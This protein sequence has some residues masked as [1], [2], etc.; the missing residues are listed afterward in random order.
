MDNRDERI[1]VLEAKVF[2]Y[3]QIISKSN[4]SPM[5]EDEK[6]SNE[7]VLKYD[8]IQHLRRVESIFINRFKDNPNSDYMVKLG[9]IIDKLDLN[10]E[11]P[12][13]KRL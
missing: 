8:E 13:K 7:S 4:F 12:L 6:S 3:E 9:E 5:L 10:Q 1:G 11:L 2:M